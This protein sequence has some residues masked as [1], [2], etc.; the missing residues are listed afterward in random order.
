MEKGAID[1]AVKWLLA[2]WECE[3][4]AGAG[5]IVQ[6][7]WFV[8]DIDEA[9]E[10]WLGKGAGPFWVGRH[11]Y[12]FDFYYRGNPAQLDL[13]VAWGQFGA[14]QIELVQQHNDGPSAF[15]DSFPGDLPEGAGA[16]Q[17]MGL[18]NPSYDTA[19]DG[20][21]AQGFECALRGVSNGTRFAFMDTRP[22]F[23][24]MLELTEMT[25]A[26]VSFYGE[27]EEAAKGWDR[28]NPIRNL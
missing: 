24:F 14:I 11:L 12:D 8:R 25:P 18:F 4:F 6:S 1:A 28:S 17:H 9:L 16:F 22:A 15:R 2:S 10:H 5:S 23:G 19:Y 20:V 21:V 3:M 27:V 13:S 7:G 26:I